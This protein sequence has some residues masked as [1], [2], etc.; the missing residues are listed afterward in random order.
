MLIS[1]QQ[2]RAMMP[3]AGRRLDA[4]LPY[5]EPALVKAAIDTPERMAAFL[6]QLA[7]ESGEFGTW[8]RSRTA[9]PTRAGPISATRS[10]ATA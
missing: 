1:E 3:N 4:H 5:I 9:A 8:R 6:A 2:L 7:H 10:P